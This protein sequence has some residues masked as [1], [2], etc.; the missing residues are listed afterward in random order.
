MTPQLKHITDR[1]QV[2]S[3]LGQGDMGAVW[4]VYDRLEKTEVEL[5]QALIPEK[6]FDFAPD[7]TRMKGKL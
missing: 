5:K 2:I 4:R 1:H 7:K 3:L 6:Q